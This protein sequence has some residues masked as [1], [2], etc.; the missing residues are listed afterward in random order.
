MRRH[1]WILALVLPLYLTACGGKTA[2]TTTPKTVKVETVKNNQEQSCPQYPGKVKAAEDIN[3]SFKVSGTIEKIYVKDGQRVRQG[4]L[5]VKLDQTDYQVQLDATEAEYNQI[6]A[7]AERII[8][9]YED[10]GTTPSNYDKAVYGL[11][12]ITAKY[13]HH[14][15]ELAY[16]Q[17][18]A[19]FDGYIQKKLFDEHETVGAGMP[20]LSMISG[21]MPEVEINLPAS[22]YVRRESFTNY[23]CTFDLYPGK[24]YPLQLISIT[25]KANSN[26]LYTMRLRVD[27]KD[28]PM[29]S[30]GLTTMVTICN[31]TEEGQLLSVPASAVLQEGGK[32][33]V[34]VFNPQEKRVNGRDITLVQLTTDGNA[35][36]TSDQVKV[37]EQI[38]SSGVHH[39]NDGESVE[40]LPA[41]SA[42][43]VGGLL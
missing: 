10:G 15:D 21:G 41:P 3:L 13:N 39:I 30:P 38:V 24:I 37:G 23:Y 17:L 5:L 36:F 11:K 29:P 9:L 4:E 8:A 35:L 40:V 22:E 25:H 18:Y 42:T 7:E 2:K 12:Q 27:A 1:Q 32:A 31:N 19:P 26:Q 14:K 33:R 34:F 43:N 28:L 6:K 16:T 20:V